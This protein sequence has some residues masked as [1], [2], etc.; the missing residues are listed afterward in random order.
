MA[1][2]V[3]LTALARKEKPTIIAESFFHLDKEGKGI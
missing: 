1:E 3:D 2:T